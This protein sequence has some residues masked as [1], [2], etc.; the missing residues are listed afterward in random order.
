MGGGS[1]PAM[2]IAG[3]T[4]AEGGLAGDVL[5]VTAGSSLLAVSAWVQVPMWPVPTTMQTF[6]VLIIGASCR[7][8][9]GAATVVAYLMEAALGLPVLAGGRP[10]GGPT[11]GY[12]AGFLLAVVVV[13]WAVRSAG[14]RRAWPR[15]FGA[16]LLGQASICLPGLAWLY[17]AWLH[18]LPATL[19]AGLLPFL[20]GDALKLSLAA[21]V[22]R[23]L[24]RVAEANRHPGDSRHA[25]D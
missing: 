18:D 23:L 22:L 7:P 11:S 15:L 5:A 9:L 10:I 14:T 8:W 24:P 21:V 20:P 3:W 1:S 16:L 17:A 19:A 13:G 12:L 2:P 4:R 25:D 6:A